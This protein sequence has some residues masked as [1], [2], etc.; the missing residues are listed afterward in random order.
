METLE[1]FLNW[2]SATRSPQTVRAYRS[3]LAGWV[4]VA[5]NATDFRPDTLRRFLRES[6]GEPRSR[7]RRL[8]ALRSFVR[9][10]RSQGVLESDP[11]ELLDTPIR[12]KTLPQVLSVHQVQTMLDQIAHTETPLRDRAMLELIYSAGLRASEVVSAR[13]AD[14]D[15][16]NRV[17][18][19]RG[20][21]R[22]DRLAVFGRLCEQSLRDYLDRERVPFA[23]PLANATVITNPRGHALTTRTLQNVVKRWC[24]SAGLPPNTSPHTLRHSFATHLLDGGAELKTVQQLLGHESLATTQIYTHMSI[25]RLEEA[26]AKAHPKSRGR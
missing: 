9:F 7:A 12:R 15:L 4:A 11:T 8:S 24:A 14:L 20:K 26:V 16:R 13:M 2:L 3:D 25:E 17:L 23:G 1:S 22:K 5:A 21:G 18:Q 10:L 6:G 19:V